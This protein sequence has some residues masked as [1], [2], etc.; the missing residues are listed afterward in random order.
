MPAVSHESAGAKRGRNANPD[1]V[2]EAKLLRRYAETRSP[3]LREQLVQKLTPFARSL[4]AR[5]RTHSEPFED[6]LQVANLGLLKAIDG[7]DPE[8]GKPFAAYAA[9]TILGELRRHFRDHVWMVRLPRGLGETTMRVDGASTALAEELGRFPKPSEIADRLEI[10][11]EDV[12][13]ALE[14]GHARRTLSLDA[15]RLGDEESTST[16]ETIASSEDGYDRVEAQLAS[17]TAGLDER[18]WRVL[19]MRFAENRSQH[20]I[21][22]ELGVSQMQISRISRKALWKLLTAVQGED[23]EGSPVPP[24]TVRSQAV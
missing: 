4:A 8:R 3:L 14:A 11:L 16:I 23:G 12:L 19:R 22:S 1:R 6:L 5:Y 10:S 7:F 17:G 15:P 21:G 20:E 13:E 18:E 2:A 9:P 24:S